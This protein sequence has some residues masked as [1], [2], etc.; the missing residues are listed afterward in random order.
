MSGKV[1]RYAEYYRDH[2]TNKIMPFWD[3]RC[4]EREGGGYQISFDREGNATDPNK[5]IWFQGRQTY[6]YAFLHNTI[7]K[8]QEWLENAAWGYDYLV[9]HAYAGNGRFNYQ[10]DR[11][12]NVMVGTTSVYADCFAIQG[13]SEYMRA[14]GCVDEEG[15]RLLNDCYD[16]LEKNIMDPNFKDIYENTWSPKFIWHDLY[17][18]ALSTADTVSDTLGEERTATLIDCCLDKILHWFAKDEYELVFEAVTRNNE[19]D[20][21][22]PQGSFINPG[23]TLEAMWFCMKIGRRRNDH[24]IIE[25]ALKIA[26]WGI[27]VGVDKQYGGIFSYLDATGRE[28]VPI[29]WYLE[30]NSLWNDKVWWANCESLCCFAMSFALSDDEA[31]LDEF[32]KLHDFCK[33]KFFDPVYGEWYERLN[34]DGSVKVADKGTK[35][36]G[37]YHLARSLIMIILSFETYQK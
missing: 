17:L 22:D 5:Y 36:K 7:D 33:D 19:V 20:L 16:A 8:R 4:I 10:L 30:T 3:A 15:M 31:F 29:D 25:R 27:K 37:A 6:I 1:E 21:Q 26:K 24:S 34:A 28:P 23:H 2:L 13:I 11:K 9:N 18:T 14:T 32:E 12:G 35:W